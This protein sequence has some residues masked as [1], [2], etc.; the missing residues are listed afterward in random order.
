M[1]RIPSFGSA[2]RR[3][4]RWRLAAVRWLLHLPPSTTPFTGGPSP[5]APTS[6]SARWSSA[7]GSTPSAS[8][9]TC[10]RRAPPR[11][12]RR[13]PFR[14]VVLFGAARGIRTKVVHRVFTYTGFVCTLRFWTKGFWTPGFLRPGFPKTRYGAGI[15]E[16]KG[17]QRRV[18]GIKGNPK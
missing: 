9:A 7:A 16:I 15:K 14:G 11:R 8:A 12:C 1:S 10:R 5:G 3:A 2:R 4:A 18:K 6:T 17:N 13:P